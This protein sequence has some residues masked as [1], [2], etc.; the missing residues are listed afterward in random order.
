MRI[1]IKTEDLEKILDQHFG[2]FENSYE[3]ELIEDSYALNLRY[4]ELRDRMTPYDEKI[5]V[6][7]ILSK[8]LAAFASVYKDPDLLA[9]HNK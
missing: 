8:K 1:H 2:G 6:R 4:P 7:P 3:L 9:P 5:A